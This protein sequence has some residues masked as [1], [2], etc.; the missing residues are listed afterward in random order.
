VFPTVRG[1]V[2]RVEVAC[3]NAPAARC[4]VHAR[5]TT[6]DGKRAGRLDAR[7]PRGGARMLEIALNARGRAEARRRHGDRLHLR[8]TLSD[9]DGRTRVAYES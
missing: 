1:G 7:P 4:R 9:P 8:V 6:P 5:L 2:Y 3:I